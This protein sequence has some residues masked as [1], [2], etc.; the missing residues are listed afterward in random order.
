[1]MDGKQ[2]DRN[3]SY[4]QAGDQFTSKPFGVAGKK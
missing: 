4:L 1:M 2:Q 3:G